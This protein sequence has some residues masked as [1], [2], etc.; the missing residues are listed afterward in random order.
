MRIDI[1]DPQR[2]NDLNETYRAALGIEESSVFVQVYAGYQHAL[3]ETTNALARLFSHKKNIAFTPSIEP[4]LEPLAAEFS[5]KEYVIENFTAD[6][7]KDEKAIASFV[8]ELLFVVV[9]QDDSITG[10]VFDHSGL[11]AVLKEKRVFKIT[12]SHAA[13]R[14]GKI[15]R[16]GLFEVKILSLAPDL[17]VVVAGERT[18]LKPLLP[19]R[20]DWLNAATPAKDI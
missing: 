12:L 3:W 4:S 17:A 10:R 6:H 11:D 19:S 7:L 16:P 8:S 14:S 5:E 15:E 2:W 9:P 20:M 1:L 18:R 13:F